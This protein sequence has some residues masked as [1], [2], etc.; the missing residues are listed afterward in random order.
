MGCPGE[1]GALDG[2]GRRL[3]ELRGTLAPSLKEKHILQPAPPAKPHS[4]PCASRKS[5]LCDLQI[6]QNVLFRH[7]AAPG[8]CGAPPRKAV[9][10]YGEWLNWANA[11]EQPPHQAA[12]RLARGSADLGLGLTSRK[13]ALCNLHLTEKR[14]LRAPGQDQDRA[15]TGPR[16]SKFLSSGRRAAILRL[17]CVTALW[18]HKL[19]SW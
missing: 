15:R 3:N 9:G 17:L 16:M 18:L 10:H 11:L 6:A 5:A 7:V 19:M 14:T 1:D 13:S 4:A 8:R 12:G 2:C